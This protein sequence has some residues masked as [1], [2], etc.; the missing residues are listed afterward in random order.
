MH[1]CVHE[2]CAVALGRPRFEYVSSFLSRCIFGLPAT[3]STS[4][5]ANA[6]ETNF[7]IRK[8]ESFQDLTERCTGALTAVNEYLSSVRQ[9][10]RTLDELY[11]FVNKIAWCFKF[12]RMKTFRRIV[13]AIV[14]SFLIVSLLAPGTAA[15]GPYDTF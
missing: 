2:G 13:Y 15:G 7:I 12:G 10:F 3:A 1:G 6:W 14:V 11:V 9:S 4:Y 8:A 5:D